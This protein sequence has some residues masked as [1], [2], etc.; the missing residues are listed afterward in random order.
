MSLKIPAIG[1]LR[2][3][4]QLLN[5]VMSAEDEGGHGVSFDLLGT[6][7]AKVSQNKGRGYFES[8]SRSAI[9]SHEVI[10]RF[11]DDF[12]AG[13]KIVYRG[14]ELEVLSVEDFNGRKAYIRCACNE[15]TVVG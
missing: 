7:W 3:R 11:R 9:V 12:F 10:M 5:K 6:V 8:D 1:T 4:V 15:K 13:D 2:E 14:G